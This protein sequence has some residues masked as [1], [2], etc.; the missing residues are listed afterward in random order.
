[1]SEKK[2]PKTIKGKGKRTEEGGKRIP[3]N[4][5]SKLPENDAPAF[6]NNM[7][8]EKYPKLGLLGR[9]VTSVMPFTP[10]VIK[11]SIKQVPVQ[12]TPPRQEKELPAIGEHDPRMKWLCKYMGDGKDSRKDIETVIQRVTL[13]IGSRIL[14]PD[15]T[16]TDFLAWVRRATGNKATLFNELARSDS[17]EKSVTNKS[18]RGRPPGITDK[19]NAKRDKSIYEKRKNG[20]SFESIAIYYEMSVKSVKTVFDKMRKRKERGAT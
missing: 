2:Q 4:K 1:M 9:I 3:A 17:K 11:K 19:K 10:T 6:S 16:R 20:E 18:N 7:P 8:P 5:I 15:F 14:T 13:L 12:N